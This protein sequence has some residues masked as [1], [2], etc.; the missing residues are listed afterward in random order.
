MGFH[1]RYIDKNLI[2]TYIVKNKMISDLF[3]ADAFIFMDK[4]SSKLYESFSYKMS[5]E[6]II[7]KWGEI[8]N[9]NV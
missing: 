8:L 1:K 3:K 5:N 6:D 4:E 9:E 2:E 7:K